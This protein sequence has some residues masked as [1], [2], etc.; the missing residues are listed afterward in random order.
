MDLVSNEVRR[1][2]R[3]F[4]FEF[5]MAPKMLVTGVYSCDANMGFLKI[6]ALEKAFEENLNRCCVTAVIHLRCF[7]D[8]NR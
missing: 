1:D 4:C 2:D 5:V 8:Y 6:L 7:F 3:F